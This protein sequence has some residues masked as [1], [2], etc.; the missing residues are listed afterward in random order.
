MWKIVNQL[1]ES[2]GIQESMGCHSLRKTFG[3]LGRKSGIP[4]EII[5]HRLNHHSIAVTHRYLGITDD[6]LADA[7]NKLDL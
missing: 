5:Q 3:Y 6:E 7:C 1:A 2:V 4:I